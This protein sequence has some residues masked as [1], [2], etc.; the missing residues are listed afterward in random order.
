[1]GNDASVPLDR[2]GDDEVTA[3]RFDSPAVADELALWCG[4]EVTHP[5]DEPDVLVILVPVPEAAKPARLGDWIVREPD[6]THR[7]YEEA[8]FAARFEPST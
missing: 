4:G 6:G 3:L 1:M 7:V 8:E 5:V 2:L